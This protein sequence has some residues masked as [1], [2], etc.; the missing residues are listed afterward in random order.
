MI[1]E[2]FLVINGLI[3]VLYLMIKGIINDFKLVRFFRGTK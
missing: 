2:M 1:I 3:I